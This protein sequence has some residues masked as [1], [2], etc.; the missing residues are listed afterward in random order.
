MAKKKRWTSED[1]AYAEARLE[2]LREHERRLTAE[3]EAR[4]RAEHHREP[5]WRRRLGLG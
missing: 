5:S 1:W 2:R 4:K 3:I